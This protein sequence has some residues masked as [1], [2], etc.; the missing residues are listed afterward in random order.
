MNIE[1]KAFELRSKFGRVLAIKVCEEAFDIIE[2]CESD[3][4]E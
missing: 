4:T 1:D 3:D 2:R